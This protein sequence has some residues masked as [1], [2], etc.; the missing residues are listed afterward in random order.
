MTLMNAMIRLAIAVVL[1][2]Q[3]AA[4]AALVIGG[5]AATGLAVH[6]RRSIGTIVDDNVL[7][8]RVRDA[9]YRHEQFNDEVRIK[10][11]AFNGWVLLAG[12]AVNEERVALAERAASGVPGVTRLFNELAPVERAGPG[13][14]TSDRWLSTR[15]NGSLTRIRELPGFDATRVKVV[16]ARGT[17]YLMGEVSHE[18]AEAVVARARTV[19]GV[20]RV[21]TLFQLPEDQ[22]S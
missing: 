8:V 20:E 10:I 19:R 14:S 3:L 1:V 5:V 17:I 12:E 16:S 7:E 13:L 4:C 22:T 9:L 2:T 15:V 6:D 21:V 18:E 11:N